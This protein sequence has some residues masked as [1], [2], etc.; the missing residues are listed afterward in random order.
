LDE[1][2]GVLEKVLE[3]QEAQFGQPKS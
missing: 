3:L 2:R 1:R